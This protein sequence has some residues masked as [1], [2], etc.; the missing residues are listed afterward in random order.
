MAYLVDVNGCW[1]RRILHCSH[2]AFSYTDMLVPVHMDPRRLL[3]SGILWAGCHNHRH[4]EIGHCSNVRSGTNQGPSC[5]LDITFPLAPCVLAFS[6]TEDLSLGS[7][8]WRHFLLGL[9]DCCALL[10]FSERE[11]V[12][13]L[14][15]LDSFEND[16]VWLKWRSESTSVFY[17][18]TKF[19]SLLFLAS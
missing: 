10:V 12:R 7:E 16:S 4:L 6:T 19:L 14:Q 18:V 8:G 13:N 3:F 11:S 15:V 17:S 9:D 1:W 5:L 2:G